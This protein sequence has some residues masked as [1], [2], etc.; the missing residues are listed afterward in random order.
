LAP[1]LQCYLHFEK[2]ENNIYKFQKV[3]KEI[4]KVAID[5]SHKR[6]KSQFKTFYILSYTKMTIS[7][8]FFRVLKSVYS[9][10]LKN[11]HSNFEPSDQVRPL[12]FIDGKVH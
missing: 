8:F 12:H 6:V 4:L 11:L 2:F 1:G 3:V 7:D 10:I 5:V 9:R